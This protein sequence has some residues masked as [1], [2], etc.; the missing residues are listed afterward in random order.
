MPV[1]SPLIPMKIYSLIIIL[2]LLPASSRCTYE[3]IIPGLQYEHVS[4]N[5]PMQ[6]IHL[7]IADP[8]QVKIEIG[9]AD[10]KCASARKTTE[11]AK[12]HNAVAAI[13]AG[14]FGYCSR[15]KIQDMIISLLDCIG[16]TKYKAFPLWTLRINN[17]YYSLSHN[18]TGALAWNN[19]KQKPLFSAIK[20]TVHLHINNSKCV[21]NELNKPNFK[22]PV[23]YC[24]TYDTHTPYSTA[25]VVEIIIKENKVSEIYLASHGKKTI[26]ENGYIYV[27]PSEYKESA[28]LFCIGDSALV[29]FSTTK[30]QD[31][32]TEINDEEWDSMDNI[33]AS[34]PLL[35]QNGAIQE[36]IKEA[37]S[38]F[39]TKRHPR[40]AVGI[41][42]NGNWVFLVAD[43]RQK[44]SKGF[45]ILEL[46]NFMKHL[47]C[48]SALNL[49]GGGSST[50]VIKNNIVNVP[51]GSEYGL[52]RSE[53]PLSNAILIS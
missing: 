37:A 47:G 31:P 11:I 34:S 17:Q 39:Y 38:P 43:G 10:N 28:E 50:M 18:F 16:Y 27:L 24:P 2:V 4:L 23:L 33:I 3:E 15:Y 41:L 20:T 45:T 19:A 1:Y 36:C 26:P 49:D 42:E 13:N 53:R 6:S 8:K 44:L 14:F 7:L 9:I 32:A 21:I 5:D 46:A 12:Q 35:I 29:T 22:G 52:T 25:S 40:T 30:K 51:S 48:I